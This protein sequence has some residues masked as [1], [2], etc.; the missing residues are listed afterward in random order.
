MTFAFD[1]PFLISLR[2]RYCHTF[3]M[4]NEFIIPLVIRVRKKKEF[5]TFSHTEKHQYTGIKQSLAKVFY[6]IITSHQFLTLF[7]A[8]RQSNILLDSITNISTIA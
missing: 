6:M 1:F 8:K 7:L 3:R 5:I 4:A 2:L